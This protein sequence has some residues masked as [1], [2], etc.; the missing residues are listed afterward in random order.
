MGCTAGKEFIIGFPVE[1]GLGCARKYRFVGMEGSRSEFSKVGLRVAP[2]PH[3]LSRSL[4]KRH[5]GRGTLVLPDR[6][7]AV[8]LARPKGAHAVAPKTRP[9][10]PW[11]GQ[12]LAHCSLQKQGLIK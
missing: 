2:R 12:C 6:H 11:M 10:M 4:R 9:A 3:R 5:W 8:S 7:T 1:S